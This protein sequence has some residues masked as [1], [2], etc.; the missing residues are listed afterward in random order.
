ML[1]DDLK[2]ID[3]K[4]KNSDHTYPYCKPNTYEPITSADNSPEI[5]VRQAP[6]KMDSAVRMEADH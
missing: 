1:P 5:L 4:R 2:I 3:M 6:M